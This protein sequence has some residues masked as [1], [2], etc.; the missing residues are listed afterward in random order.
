VLH[1]HQ[2]RINIQMGNLIKKYPWLNIHSESIEDYIPPDYYDNL[3][4]DYVFLGK[5][6]LDFFKSYLSENIKKKYR[7][8]A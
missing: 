3:L 2:E 6:D 4:K 8:R 1:Y 5:L 7:Q